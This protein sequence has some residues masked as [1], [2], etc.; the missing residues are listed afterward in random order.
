MR[1]FFLL[2]PLLFLTATPVWSS[3]RGI[4]L[5]QQIMNRILRALTG[6]QASIHVYYA[7]TRLPKSLLKNPEVILTARPENADVVLVDSR[8]ADAR[9][10]HL[11]K[12]ILT[13]DYGALRDYPNA[14]GAYFW[15]KG[16]PN[17]IMIRA[18]LDRERIRL[19]AEFDRYIEDSIW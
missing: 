17:I 8:R 3:E 11:H 4:Q 15:Q 6:K 13:L 19:P 10:T 7:G 5:E 16:R 14:V 9:L 1:R 12:P 2:L 18:R